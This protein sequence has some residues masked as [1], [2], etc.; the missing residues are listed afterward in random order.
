ML[1]GS[2]AKPREKVDTQIRKEATDLKV[3]KKHP[4]IFKNNSNNNNNKK[5]TLKQSLNIK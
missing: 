3:N 2:D 1:K 4:S 5:K